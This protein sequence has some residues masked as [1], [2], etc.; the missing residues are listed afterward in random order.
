[1]KI[2]SIAQLKGCSTTPSSERL[3]YVGNLHS[4]LFR[5][6]VARL[7]ELLGVPDHT[8]LDTG[9]RSRRDML[10][11]LLTCASL[12]IKTLLS[13]MPVKIVLHGAY[14]PV[15]WSLLM[16]RRVHAI[17]ILQ[18][19][20][21]N[22]DF[23]GLRARLVTLILQRSA[24]VVCRNEAQRNLAVDLCRAQPERCVIVN[25]G[26]NKA[27][28][29]LPLPHRSGD[30]VL[31][32]PRATQTEY[33]I[34]VIFAA[35]AKL[36]KEGY[37][38]RFIYVRFNPTFDLEDISIADEILEAPPQNVLWGKLAQADLCISVPDYDG[39]SNTILETLALGSTP[40]FSDLPPYA[41]LKQDDRLGVSVALGDSFEQ[42]VERLYLSLQRALSHIGEHRASAGFRRSFAEAHFREGA[43]VERIVEAL[44]A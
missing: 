40:L 35:V 20:E 31:I 32:S 29:D 43:G 34:P 37:R 19:S 28:F 27:L 5:Q 24:L 17:S 22:V 41:F 26:L 18:G 44:R 36:K 42:K 3:V 11:F 16:L 13:P 4:V 15:L 10:R 6:R 33:N 9:R 30:P 38:A 39:L 14:S 23:T 2:Y 1:M 8:V 7:Q 21:L 12:I 25:W